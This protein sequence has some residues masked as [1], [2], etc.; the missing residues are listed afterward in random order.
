MPLPAGGGWTCLTALGEVG[1]A[2]AE[3]LG[4][5]IFG[6]AAGRRAIGD[7]AGRVVTELF[8]KRR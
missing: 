8:S 6:V 2:G 1:A 3:A 5:D 7:W 4:T